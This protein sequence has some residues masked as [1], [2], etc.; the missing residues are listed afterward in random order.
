MLHFVQVHGVLLSEKSLEEPNVRLIKNPRLTKVPSV[1]VVGH[2]VD[3]TVMSECLVDEGL[4]DAEEFAYSLDRQP[5]LV[6]KDWDP[7]HE[8][9]SDGCWHRRGSGSQYQ[10]KH[11]TRFHFWKFR[12]LMK[13]TVSPDHSPNPCP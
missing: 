5:L 6:S 8:R 9:R 12:R 1:R 11:T 13:P 3:D 10:I 7:S 4:A 2:L